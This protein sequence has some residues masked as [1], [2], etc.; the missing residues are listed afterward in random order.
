MMDERLDSH[1]LEETMLLKIYVPESVSSLDTYRLAI[2]QDGD[3]YYQL[4]RAATLSD[5]LH[6]NGDMEN[7]ILIGIHYQDKY[8]RQ[9]KYHPNGS[10]QKAYMS[11]LVQE[12]VP[13][14]D[15]RLPSSQV[16]HSRA[17]I[18]DSL[19]GTLALMTALKYP[20]TFGNVIM[21][22]PYVDD[23]VLDTVTKAQTLHPVSTYHTIGTDETTVHTTD[24]GQAD[25]LTPNRQLHEH[26]KKKGLPSV[27]HELEHGNHTW[28]YWQDDLKHAFAALFN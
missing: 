4:G 12:V 26:I 7:T 18:G 13:F 14:L 25:F 16:G 23:T 28:K 8:D 20:K 11:F 1:Y 3:D 5:R 27:Y 6:E 2:M 19:A 17:L 21:Q 9:Q 24:G 22:S 15:E 10:Q